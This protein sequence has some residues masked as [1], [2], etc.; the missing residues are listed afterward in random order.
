MND[1][2]TSAV[3]MK[4]MPTSGKILYLPVL[5]IAMP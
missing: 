2:E 5:L 1:I 4:A 3:T